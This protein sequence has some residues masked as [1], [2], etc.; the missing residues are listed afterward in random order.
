VSLHVKVYGNHQKLKIAHCTFIQSNFC[1]LHAN[2]TL[3]PVT[4]TALNLCFH[5]A[6]FLT[7]NNF[8]LLILVERGTKISGVDCR[9]DP[10]I[11]V[12]VDL[13]VLKLKIV[14]VKFCLEII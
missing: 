14:Q 3:S 11:E 5:R 6:T 2:L 9:Y 10:Y 12:A 13:R 4:C 1:S 7:S 8:I